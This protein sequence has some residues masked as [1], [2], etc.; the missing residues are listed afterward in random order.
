M[1]LDQDVDQTM[2]SRVK[3]RSTDEL[4]PGQICAPFV[5]DR[6]IAVILNCPRI[7]NRAC[8]S[9]E[10]GIEIDRYGLVKRLK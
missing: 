3:R 7:P 8:L 10:D 2:D 5:C 4:R 9:N 1:G 6:K